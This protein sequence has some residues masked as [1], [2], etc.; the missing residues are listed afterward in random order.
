ML[1]DFL[2]KEQIFPLSDYYILYVFF[3][4]LAFFYKSTDSIRED[5]TLMT[6][7]VP[8]GPHLLIPSHW[9]LG[10]QPINFVAIQL[11]S[12]VHLFA[13]LWTAAR[14]NPLSLTIS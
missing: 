7:A 14:Q 9:A 6:Q 1:L 4:N 3:G 8:R 2:F 10:F 5:S 13:T 11:L 12:R